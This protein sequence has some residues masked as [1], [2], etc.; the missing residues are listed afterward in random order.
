MEET[1]SDRLTPA[2]LKD[3]GLEN[4]ERSKC[5]LILVI[6]EEVF[7]SISFLAEKTAFSPVSLTGDFKQRERGRRRGPQALRK[8]PNIHLRMTGGKNFDVLRS[9]R[10]ETSHFDVG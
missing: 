2:T 7:Y 8:N 9:T 6:A 4:I 5:Q 1:L 10:R 3:C